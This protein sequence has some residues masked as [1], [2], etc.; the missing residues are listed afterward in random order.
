MSII[1]INS[2]GITPPQQPELGVVIGVVVPSSSGRD[3]PTIYFDYDTFKREFDDGI[4]SLAKYKFL[5]EKGYQVAA[6]RVN[7]DEP[8]FATLR[9]SDPVYTD[10]IATHPQYLDSMPVDR[11]LNKDKTLEDVE[12]SDFTNVFRLN[13]GDLTKLNAAKDYILIPSGLNPE[14]ASLTLITFEDGVHGITGTEA[15]GPNVVRTAVNIQNKTTAQIRE[16]IKNVIEAY[17]QYKVMPGQEEEDFDMF[18]QFIFSD[19][20][21]QWNLTPG[22]IDIDIDYNDKLDVIASYASPYKIMDFASTIPGIFGNMLNIQIQGFNCKVYY[23]DELLE[24][25]NFSSTED[26]FLQLKENSPYILPVLHDRDKNLPDGTYFFDGGF[27]EAEKTTDD[28]LRALE[29]FGDEDIDI[30]FL[31]YDEFFDPEL[32][33]L[34]MLHQ[35]SVENQFLVLL[36]MDIARTYSNTTNIF[37]TIGTYVRNGVELPTSY[38]FFDRLTTDYAGVIKEK[39]YINKQ[40]TEEEYKKFE[41]IGLNHIKYDGYNYYIS[42]YYSTINENPAYKFSMNR[43]QRKFRRLQ[44]FLGTKKT[45]LHRYIQ[46]LTTDLRDEIYLIDDIVLTRFNYDDRMGSAEIQLEVT[47]SQMIN[48]VLLLNVII[49]RN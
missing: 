9:I 1:K 44:Q 11:S 12:I 19:E 7:K 40:Y 37:Y 38:A 31:S 32:R 46:K 23:D 17:T 29:L 14:N 5:F 18:Y 6:A 41:E 15:F 16:G 4:T 10:L 28:Y 22:T 21:E 24:D 39:I 3:Y 43:V 45:E 34:S 36:N 8:N 48:E 13:Y 30:D 2:V 49:N 25:Y 47:L 27:V 35:V 42:Y 33:I 26:L 20:I